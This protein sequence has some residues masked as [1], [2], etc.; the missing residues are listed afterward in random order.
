MNRAPHRCRRDL[1]QTPARVAASIRSRM[2]LGGCRKGGSP[3]TGPS[4]EVVALEGFDLEDGRIRRRCAAR[5]SAGEFRQMG[6]PL[7]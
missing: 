1:G 6:L 7:S 4:V 2:V 5:D 3:V